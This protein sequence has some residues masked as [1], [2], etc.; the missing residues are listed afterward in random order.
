EAILN[1][2][3]GFGEDESIVIITDDQA[4][5]EAGSL[6]DYAR[7]VSKDAALSVMS[8]REQ[9]A[10]EPPQPVAEMIKSADCAVL[11]TTYSMTH[12]LA[13]TNATSAGTR[14]ISMP[15]ACDRMF[16]DGSVIVDVDR[17]QALGQ[18]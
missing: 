8:V 5:P 18:W 10:E 6:F 1:T 7:K 13:R 16:T 11:V 14:I 9:H 15:G 12:S 3:L 4:Q 17:T 2:A